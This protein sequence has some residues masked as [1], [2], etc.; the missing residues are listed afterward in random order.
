MMSR[1][2]VSG[3]TTALPP[4][5]S[6]GTTSLEE[7]LARRRSVREFAREA[8]S[9]Q[10][11]SQLAWA[12]QGITEPLEGLRTAPSAGALYPLQVYLVRRDGA[13][14]YLPQ[15]HALERVADGDRR[16]PLAAAALA[17]DWIASAPLVVVI[18]A[19]FGR[20]R[21]RYGD[22]AERYACLEAGHVAQNIHLEAVSLGL[23]SVPVGAFEDDRVAGVLE[24]RS[25]EHPL[26]LIAVGRPRSAT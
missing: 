1:K 14:R 9:E 5:R 7:C 13:F 12:A 16:G 24:L 6:T 18:A 17:Q 20:L 8:L 23:A 22:R 25:G 26:Y 19:T 2:A 15:G 11:I 10:E 3:P 4:F 21:R